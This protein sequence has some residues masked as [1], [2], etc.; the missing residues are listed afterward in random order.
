MSPKINERLIDLSFQRFG[1][2]TVLSY[3]SD[4]KKWLCLC[5]C[6]N[7]KFA[8]SYNLRIGK[9]RNCGCIFDLTG[10]KFGKLTVLYQDSN[11]SGCFCGCGKKVEVFTANLK[12]GN[13][14]SCG[15]LIPSNYYEDETLSSKNALF[16]RY[17]DRA[18]K[19]GFSFSLEFDEFI[20]LVQQNCFYCGEK[21]NQV[22]RKLRRKI[23]FYN[24]LDRLQ[25]SKGYEID[26]VVSCCKDCNHA[27]WDRDRYEFICWLKR[28]YTHLNSIGLLP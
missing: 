23:F 2:L 19:R 16:W 15:C 22:D 4:L 11:K 18:K 1:K 8:S 17:K 13:T 3:N 27:K 6:G 25:N 10:Q 28:C 20:N 21:P 26:N 24:G 12:R 14:R 9:T 7:K 5:D